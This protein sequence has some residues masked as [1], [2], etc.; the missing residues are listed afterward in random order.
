MLFNL[1]HIL[2]DDS[3][4]RQFANCQDIPLAFCLLAYLFGWILGMKQLA[5]AKKETD[6]VRRARSPQ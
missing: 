4:D 1:S 3:V 2:M 6:R 5:P